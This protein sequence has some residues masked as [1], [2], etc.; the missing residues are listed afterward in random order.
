MFQRLQIVALIGVAGLVLSGCGEPSKETGTGRRAPSADVAR[1]TVAVS[2]ASPSPVTTSPLAVVPAARFRGGTF[3]PPHLENDFILL[4]H[5]GVT[6]ATVTL[7][8]T[9]NRLSFR[10]KPRLTPG[11]ALPIVDITL[12]PAAEPKGTV[13]V[14]FPGT[15]VSKDETFTTAAVIPAGTYRVQ[16]GYVRHTKLG[17]SGVVRPHVEFYGVTFE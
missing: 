6:S 12:E 9:A 1:N 7:P 11:N 10:A 17:E 16:L 3:E 15:T 4:K 13:Y 14:L 8:R 5:F 2:K